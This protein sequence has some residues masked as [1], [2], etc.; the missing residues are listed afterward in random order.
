MADA[1]VRLPAPEIR[2]PPRLCSV[3]I[4][5]TDKLELRTTAALFKDRGEG[6]SRSLVWPVTNLRARRYARDE[7][8]DR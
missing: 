7:G 2:E 3:R 8:A 6:Q 1:A 4:E 5:R